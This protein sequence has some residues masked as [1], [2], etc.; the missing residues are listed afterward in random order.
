MIK[1]YVHASLICLALLPVASASALDLRLKLALP[2]TQLLL[3]AVSKPLSQK[4]GEISAEEYPIA[5]E[6]RP[7][8]NAKDYKAALVILQKQDSKTM[9]AALLMIRAQIALQ[10]QQYPGAEKDFKAALVLLP[11]FVR[12]HQGLALLYLASKQWEK[13]HP[14][15]TTVISLGGGDA[16]I[17]GQLAYLN[18]SQHNGWSAVSAYQHALML[19]PG[20]KSYQEGL[21]VAL[22]QTKQLLSAQSLVEEMLSADPGNITLWLQRAN[23]ALELEDNIKALGSLEVAVR[24]GDKRPESRLVAA[25]L[26]MKTKNFKRATQLLQ[27][28]I[29]HNQWDMATL[30]EV[31]SWLA[32]QQQWQHISSLLDGVAKH[33][34]KMNSQDLSRYYLHRAEL[35]V[36]RG[37]T[38]AAS[39]AYTKAINAN[40][41]NGSA[42]IAH[43][44]MLAAS[45]KYTH[46]ELLYNR[47]QALVSVREKALLGQAQLFIDQRN[48]PAALEL[49]RKVYQ[50]YPEN[51]DLE[52]NIR[53]L[54]SIIGVREQTE[55]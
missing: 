8:L 55:I 11:D 9:S 40:P 25:Q 10:L 5:Q 41:G 16:Q 26:H 29:N 24:L 1:R 14:A 38:K 36:G 3:P 37:K 7:L 47:A 45:K 33:T 48:Y 18:L 13:A 54:V 21:L 44:K 49:L 39:K 17:Y 27:A 46:A 50:E 15:L 34:K 32:Y 31:L 42:L 23:T 20:N 35:A 43:A 51:R 6:L 30:D 28:N 22:M 19:A 12:A 2:S 52:H 53:S 4:E